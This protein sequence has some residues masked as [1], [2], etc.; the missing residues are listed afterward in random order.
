[1]L[2]ILLSPR[3]GTTRIVL[4]AACA[5]TAAGAAGMAAGW[6]RSGLSGAV[7]TLAYGGSWCAFLLHLL[8]KQSALDVLALRAIVAGGVLIAA[9]VLGF[10]FL[11]RNAAALGGDGTLPLVGELATRLAL[12]VYGALLVENLYRNAHADARWHLNMLCVGLGGMFAFSILV[13]ADGLLFQ[14]ISPLLWSGQA[15]AA[16]MATPLLAVAVARNRHWAIDIHV[17]RAV[18]F[19]TATLV[20]SGIFLL[21]LAATGEVFRG[22]GAGWG[23]LTEM[24][25]LIAGV[26]GIA[27]MLTSASARSYIRRLLEDNFYSHRYDYRQEWLKSIETLAAVPGRAGIQAR[28]IRAVADVADSPAGV[29]FVRDL[30]S[31]AFQWAG[32]WNRPAVPVAMPADDAFAALF[33]GGEWVIELAEVSERPALLA[34]IPGAWLAVPLAQKAELIGFVVLVRP[35]APLR[36]TRETFDLLRIVA[37]QSATHVAEQRMAQALAEIQQ[38]SDYSRRFAF[39]VHDMKNVASQLGMIVQN[40]RVHRDDPEFQQDVLATVGSAFE[41]MSH[42][43]ARLRPS[44]PPVTDGLIVP[45]D[46]VGDEVAALCRARDAAIEIETDGG[47]AAVAM[48]E[49]AF[50]SVIRH[51]CENAL[52]AS[53]ERVVVRLQ[54]GSLRLEIAI[55]DDGPGMDAEFVRD[56]LFQPLGSGKRDGFGIGAYQARELVRAAGGDLLAVT[57]PSRGTTMRIILPCVGKRAQVAPQLATRAAQ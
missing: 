42:L 4:A 46:L 19:H 56:R 13:Y 2:L 53:R 52:E 7:V 1:L 20:G 40:A 26:A 22:L 21:A 35:R 30:G 33:R 9:A 8:R 11:P 50:R 32:S 16:V 34:E 24:T 37:R 15:I 39:V 12:A 3:G 25:L 51:L 23:E 49:A 31:T 36:L 55:A 41:K 54:H 44:L 29:L 27:V 45:A 43:L 48:D 38:L 17:S 5:M 28:V 6:G 57:R 47:A 10:A 18:V 14:R